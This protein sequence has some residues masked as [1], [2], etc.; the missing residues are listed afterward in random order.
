MSDAAALQAAYDQ[1][2]EGFVLPLLEGGSPSVTRPLAPGCM[3]HFA[4]ASSASPEADRRIFDVLYRGASSHAPLGTIAWPS[5][6][7]VAMAAALH[8]LLFLTDPAL[9]RLFARGARPIIRE[10]TWRWIELIELPATRG[11]ALA[12]HVL[13]SRARKLRRRDV[14]VRN[15]AYTYRFFGRRVPANVV[16]LPRLRFVRQEES[17]RPFGEL[18]ESERDPGLA[19]LGLRELM[20][21]LAERSPMTTLLEVAARPEF[22]FSTA[23]LSVLSDRAL[24]GAVA[25]ALAEDEWR[26]AA[27]LARA[28]AD[29][30]LASAPALMAIAI[31]LL[32]ELHLTSALAGEAEPPR[33]ATSDASVLRYLAIL[34]ASLDDDRAARE[35]GVLTDTHRLVLQ[36]RAERYRASLP[37]PLLDE[38]RAQLASALAYEPRFLPS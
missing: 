13:L 4:A 6:G 31:Q 12:R 29:P 30:T 19:K 23:T 27:N 34:V 9:D 16:A 2:V 20:G 26:A 22:R 32:L 37:P 15:W 33:S 18:F 35:L 28:S 1:L 11:E 25:R 10:W 36:R 7:L 21:E 17:L 8:D 38:V 24:R 5:R 14:V 3:S